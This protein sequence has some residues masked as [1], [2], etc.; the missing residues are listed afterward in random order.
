M[1]LLQDNKVFVMS[2]TP[3]ADVVPSLGWYLGSSAPSSFY[4][5]LSVFYVK[6]SL[7]NEH[8]FRLL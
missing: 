7:T 2:F 1:R 8:E 3:K 6:I 5:N 4:D